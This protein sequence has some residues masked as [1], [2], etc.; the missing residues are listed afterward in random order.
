M[1][2]NGCGTAQPQNCAPGLP[3]AEPGQAV[4]EGASPPANYRLACWDIS[5]LD[6][7]GRYT[8]ASD[9]HQIG[10]MLQGWSGGVNGLSADGRRF[11]TALVHKELDAAAAL[12]HDWLQQRASHTSPGS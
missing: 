7:E 3:P 9:M 2:H 12:H 4:R 1:L 11:I 5:T 8:A 6:D 10:V